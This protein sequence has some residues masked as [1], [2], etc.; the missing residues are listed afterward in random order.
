MTTRVDGDRVFVSGL[1]RA[2][3]Y[4]KVEAETAYTVEC[5][6]SIEGGF[7]VHGAIYARQLRFRGNGTTRSCVV[8]RGEIVLDV[9]GIA[10]QRFLG[11]LVASGSV[12]V[13]ADPI[14]IKDSVGGDIKRAKVL[15]RGDV[16]GEAVALRD[17]VVFGNIQA[18]RIVL[19]RCIV[20]GAVV[21]REELV[22]R[23]ST[24]LYY[25]AQTVRFEGPCMCL[26]AMGESIE[27]P[28]FAP[29]EDVDETIY[30]PSVL[31]Y[32]VIRGREDSAL[33][34]RPWVERPVGTAAGMLHPPA[35]WVRV[36]IEQPAPATEIRDRHDEPMTK[37]SE[38]WV[39]SI[40]GRAMHF[41]ILS[42]NI[43]A[44]GRMLQTAF[45]YDH[46]VEQAQV[47]ARLWIEQQCTPDERWL[48]ELLALDADP[49]SHESR[50]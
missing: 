8:G 12:E 18:R 11:G 40:A 22:L 1:V 15:V 25:H 36:N 17:T 34:N 33:S 26:H 19:E 48:M 37:R 14:T 7:D 39:L 16:I 28:V 13:L 50:Q 35:D 20:V 23:G 32:P 43:R 27:R 6:G 38:R 21:A 46:Y 47:E 42:L 30:P 5:D 29:F 44:I 4:P 3:I 45:E 2:S 10:R 9:R 31:Y 41:G 49:A 24:V